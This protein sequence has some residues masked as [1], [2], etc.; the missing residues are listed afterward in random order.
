MLEAFLALAEKHQSDAVVQLA[1]AFC[2][3]QCT[4][5]VIVR[6][7]GVTLSHVTKDQVHGLFEKYVLNGE[8]T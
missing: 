8:C 6:I 7:N 1:G 3:E 5:G 4:E 2:Q